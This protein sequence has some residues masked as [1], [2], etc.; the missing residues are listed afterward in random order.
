MKKVSLVPSHCPCSPEGSLWSPGRCR[1]RSWTRTWGPRGRSGPRSAPWSTW[2][3]SRRLISMKKVLR[4][5]VHHTHAQ[6]LDGSASL[7][8]KGQA[9]VAGRHGSNAGVCPWAHRG[10]F[11]LN[12]LSFLPNRCLSHFSSNLWLFCCCWERRVWEEGDGEAEVAQQRRHLFSMAFGGIRSS[13][14]WKL[15]LNPSVSSSTTNAQKITPTN[16]TK[17]KK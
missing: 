15:Q 9:G 1:R 3:G 8:L 13:L 16:W 12:N 4:V 5:K 11:I 17:E 14:L 6:A 2:W 10:S 7:M